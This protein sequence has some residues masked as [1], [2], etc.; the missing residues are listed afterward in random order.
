[1]LTLIAALALLSQEQPEGATKELLTE[2][3]GYRHKILYESFRD[4]NWEIY[5]ANADGSNATNLTKSADID[6]LYPKGSPDG[7]KIA[8][9]ADEGKGDAKVRNLYVMNLDGSGRK[10][11]ADNSREPC[12]SADSKQVAYLP[13]EFEKFT[14]SDFATKGIRIYDLATGQTKDHPNNAKIHH[15]YTLN[16]VAG[17]QW[18]VSTVH[19]GMGFKHGILA[20]EAEGEGFYDLKLDGC[21]PDVSPDGKKII[22]GHG[23]YKIGLA[24]LDFTSKPPTAKF[25]K[26][27]V[28]SKDPV[29]TYHCDWSP[30]MKYVSFSLG[31]KLKGKGLKGL[32]PEFPG[33]EAPGWNTCVADV[34]QVNRWAA[35]TLDGKSN[36]ESDWVF[37]PE[38][39]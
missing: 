14:Y 35:I 28:E 23:D 37:V 36:K 32:L 26:D 7:T 27:I 15:L 39:K 25:I 2:L 12:W 21:R 10:K 20:L 34:S 22:W 4:G 30:D 29:E 24:E 5:I 19:G 13:G 6:E 11:I 31:A 9:C 18:F 38:N 33:V 8:F 3:K 1:M 17:N 16:Y